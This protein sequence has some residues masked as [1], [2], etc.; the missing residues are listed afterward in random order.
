VSGRVDRSAPPPPGPSAPFRFP[1]YRR[2]V[3]PGGLELFVAPRAGAP[4]VELLLLLPAGGEL[5]PR[6]RP[7]L[8]TLTAALADEGTRSR[9]GLE[10]AL[11]LERLGASL[12]TGA[13][14]DKAYLELSVLAQDLDVGLERLVEVGRQPSFPETEVERLRAQWLADIYRR[15]DQPASL[16]DE[17]LQAALFAGTT[18]EHP[19][20]GTEASLTDVTR[21]EVARFH[22]TAWRGDGAALLAGGDVDEPALRAAVERLLGDWTGGSTPPATALAPA[23]PA[24]RR[25]LLV[26]L[27]H[28]TQTEL[29]LGQAGV[30]RTH[31][32]RPGLSVLN[33]VLGGKFTSRLNLN[34]RERRG[35]TYGVSSR[36]VDRKGPGPFVVATAVATESTGA[37]LGEILAELERL[38][39]EPVSPDELA[40]TRDYLC[41]VFPYTLQTVG[42]LLSRLAELAVHR[43]PDGYFEEWLKEIRL[44]SPERLLELARRHLEPDRATIVAVG[45]AAQLAPQLERFGAL[46]RLAVEAPRGE[47]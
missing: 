44:A 3:L 40:E 41:G 45:P 10:L 13:D 16:A 33:G 34:L 18:Y 8:A 9:S 25:V 27:P 21:D 14:W 24:A 31:P 32:D 37:A 1:D 15:R 47:G 43:L 30:P 28:A 36:F 17:A 22:A 39:Q 26:D 2:E 19:L 38:R 6:E 5:N 46:T 7:G 20:Q 35:F 4:L 12:S 29:R 11:E 42:G 23:R